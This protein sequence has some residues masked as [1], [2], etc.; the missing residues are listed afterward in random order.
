MCVP[1]E[2][3][4]HVCLSSVCVLACVCHATPIEFP[5]SVEALGNSGVGWAN[6]G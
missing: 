1:C 6:E 4:V 2:Q 5:A 3:C